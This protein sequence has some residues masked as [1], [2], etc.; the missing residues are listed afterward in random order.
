MGDFEDADDQ[1]LL[2]FPFGV[3]PDHPSVYLA[4]LELH[5]LYPWDVPFVRLVSKKGK[6]DITLGLLD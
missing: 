6:R 2:V 4:I 1:P 5:I 3:R